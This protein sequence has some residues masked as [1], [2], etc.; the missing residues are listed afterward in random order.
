MKVLKIGILVVGMFCSSQANAYAEDG[1][2]TWPVDGRI[3]DYFGTRNGK[4]YG[5][6]IAASIG[7]PVVA[8][9]GG[10]VTKS[11]FSNSY[12]HVV[13]VKH[14]EY[15]A[16][17]AHLNKRYVLQGERIARGEVIGE[18]GNTG[19][20]RGAHLHLEVHKGAWT[21]G[22]RNAMNPLLV[23]NEEKHQV[24]SSSMY[25]VQKGDTLVSIARKFGMTVYEIK[26]KNALRQDRIYP[27][28][29]LYIN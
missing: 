27:N 2:W 25:V 8:I 29:K 11:Y 4:H 3:S 1:R 21:F 7:T 16:V 26:A 20:S 19:E 14:G 6:D 13:F 5:I 18:V 12:G 23:L 22:K 17:Y 28:Q 9:R 24:A 10:T 15:E